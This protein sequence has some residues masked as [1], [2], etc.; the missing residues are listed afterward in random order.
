MLP[1]IIYEVPNLSC[2]IAAVEQ[3]LSASVMAQ[4]SYKLDNGMTLVRCLSKPDAFVVSKPAIK[5][6]KACVFDEVSLKWENRAWHFRESES[7][8]YAAR[9]NSKGLC[10]SLDYREQFY[11]GQQW[12]EISPDMTLEASMEIKNLAELSGIALLRKAGLPWERYSR[13]ADDPSLLHV[14]AVHE[15]KAERCLNE[16]DR[17]WPFNKPVQCYQAIMGRDFSYVEWMAFA[18]YKDGSIRFKGTSIIIA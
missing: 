1:I 14:A 17:I 4:S 7:R 9:I 5:Q 10:P 2:D 11:P 3:V 12:T 13:N 16:W 8:K 6:G 15:V 18:R